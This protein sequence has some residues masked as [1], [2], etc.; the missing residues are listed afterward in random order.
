MTTN[1]VQK[2]IIAPPVLLAAMLLLLLGVGG[3]TAWAATG[4]NLE[5]VWRL[6]TSHLPETYT[7]L[8]YSDPAHLPLY[9]PAGKKQAVAFYI[10]NHEGT[11]KT[12]AYEIET[13]ENGQAFITSGS[14]TLID[15]QAVQK[16]ATFV[17]PKP[18]EAAMTTIRLV[19]ENE[20]LTLRSQ[21]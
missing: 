19:G 17:I 10:V 21:S 3:Y 6:A 12:Y 2:T 16:I 4:K 20:V 14:A 18:N 7:A 5:N 1:K 9:A 8:Y 11:T 13:V 15:G